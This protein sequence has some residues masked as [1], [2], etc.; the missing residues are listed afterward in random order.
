MKTMTQFHW[1]RA[2]MMLLLVLLGSVGAWAQD[3]NLGDIN[4]DCFIDE[5]DVQLI[6]D[7]IMHPSATADWAKY[8]INGDKTVNAADIVELLNIINSDSRYINI[9]WEKDH[10]DSFD[11]ETG[12]A[13]ITFA[14]KVPLM[15]VYDVVILPQGDDLVIRVIEEVTK[16]EGLTVTLATSKGELGNLFKNTSFTLS[17]GL[18]DEAGAR[19]RGASAPRV[20]T[21]A[22]I[23]EFDGQRFVEVYHAGMA[24]TRGVGNPT[25]ETKK[26]KLTYDGTG[27]TL[28]EGPATVT[29]DKF[30]FSFELGT[31]VKLAFTKENWKKVK[32]GTILSIDINMKAHCDTDIETTQSFQNAPNTKQ[33]DIP[34]DAIQLKSTRR[35]YTFM[36]GKVPLVM[37]MGIALN[38]DDNSYQ[39]WV[40]GTATLK[41]SFSQHGTMEVQFEDNKDWKKA[42]IGEPIND[43]QTV[44]K[45][46]EFTIGDVETEIGT[47]FGHD[48][49]ISMSIMNEDIINAAY[50]VD[51]II[52]NAESK[53]VN[54]HYGLWSA[55][56][57]SFQQFDIDDVFRGIPWMPFYMR[58][59]N[60]N[61]KATLLN[62]SNIEE[63]LPGVPHKVSFQLVHKDFQ[64]LLTPSPFFVKKL[65]LKGNGTFPNGQK[66]IELIAD[67]EGV[68]S[69]EVTCGP[70]E[71]GGGVVYSDF[72]RFDDPE[73]ECWAF[74]P[75]SVKLT[76]TTPEVTIPKDAES[77][78]VKFRL[79]HMLDKNVRIGK[80]KDPE[81][82]DEDDPTKVIAGGFV[83]GFD[84]TG[85]GIVEEPFVGETVNFTAEN[86]SVSPVSAVTNDDGVVTTTFTQGSADFTEG[87][88]TGTYVLKLGESQ[89]EQM[90]TTQTATITKE[91]GAAPCDT[92]DDNL[93]K[94]DLQ[95]NTVVITNKTTGVTKFV[96]IDLAKSEW[97]KSTDV[98][99]YKL[100]SEYMQMEGHI[101]LTMIGVV[102][103]LTGQTFENTPGAKV[104]LGVSGDKPIYAD[105]AKF[106]DQ[107]AFGGIKPESMVLLRKPCNKTKPAQ[108][109]GTRGTDDEE[110]TDEYELLFYLVF[111]NEIDGEEYEAYGKGTMVMHIPSIT[112]FVLN[113]DKDWV[114]V[115]ES[116]K[117]GL[118]S[119]YE[120]GA[121]WDWNDVELI[122][123]S[124]KQSDAK[125]GTNDGYF[126]WDAATQTLTSVKSNDNKQVWVYLGLKSDPSVKAPALIATGEGW[127][128]TM[129]STSET[130]MTQ[131]ANSHFRF[132]FDFAPKGSED[133]KIDFS[134]LELDPETNP[135]GYF[136][137]LSN[138]KR[139]PI[140][141]K[142]DTPPGEYTLRFWV[143]SNHDVN[144][145]MKII[146]TPEE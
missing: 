11:P 37:I 70:L 133:E 127:K 6:A 18:D 94:A 32:K 24:K 142:S 108:T 106:T 100:S 119:F 97:K 66:E 123:Q 52:S 146:I 105:F 23:E 3:D 27:T 144:C 143:K 111:T 115:G 126:T 28:F 82:H 68:I 80:I 8:D 42:K 134:A 102:A 31:T 87:T 15:N 20:I 117:V 116:T 138:D 104:F 140:F 57:G 128:Y 1:A 10:L 40:M 96:N 63:V 26:I 76:C 39:S 41:R 113:Y 145:T 67:D 9:D 114:K 84:Y 139:W 79:T 125:N 95:D 13:V 56:F 83:I 121:E 47:T 129:I 44:S 124:I 101:P 25:A 38:V 2:A 109:R 55:D 12:V 16:T 131:S 78:P 71:A 86:G 59:E 7:Y 4:D 122:G 36:V 74:T 35:R 98:L 62:T 81:I 34:K 99:N 45:I 107:E 21:P 141:A 61:E 22:K 73:N 92:G 75:T 137:F 19:S 50:T 89:Q 90:T 54:G 110:Y 103:A 88:A 72:N 65:I 85:D 49:C 93:N 136:K 135:N 91:S 77:A 5:D 69:T 51:A 53:E 46:T 14:D 33:D 30:N 17:F 64:D 43:Q 60:Y 118:T 130:E 29:F 112:S 48:A 132:D 58:G 120:E